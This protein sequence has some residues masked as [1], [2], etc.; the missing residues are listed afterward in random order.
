[1]NL[2]DEN[3]FVENR[4][5]RVVEAQLAELK[6]K[7]N[8]WFDL[9]VLIG[10]FFLVIYFKLYKGEAPS[11]VLWAIAA[12]FIFSWLAM[13]LPALIKYYWLALPDARANQLAYATGKLAYNRGYVLQTDDLRLSLPGDKNG[14]LL[15][16]HHY[17]VC[18]LPRAKVVISA[19]VMQPVS[20]AQQ[21]REFTLLFGQL[22]GFTDEDIQANRN[23]EFIFNQKMTIMKRS[24]WAILLILFIIALALSQIIPMLMHPAFL[25]DAIMF[26]VCMGGLTFFV[27]GAILISSRDATNLLATFERKLDKKAGV[28]HLSERTTGYGKSRATR[29]YLGVGLDFELQIS[30]RAYEVLVDGLDCRVYYAPRFKYLASLEVVEPA[31]NLPGQ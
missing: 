4:N 31:D 3:N 10:A 16:G 18:Y 19:R 28:V 21:A 14:G 27:I 7:A 13:R 20:A 6:K 22:L 30:R 1:M 12:I 24:W 2:L 8:I 23:G 26:T 15:A 25:D 9:L 5:G 17:E 29:Y 11:I